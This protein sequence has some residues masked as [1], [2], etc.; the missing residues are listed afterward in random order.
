[1]AGMRI[2]F[3]GAVEGS[4]V[5]LKTLI[6]LGH[7]PVIVVTLPPEAMQRHADYVDLR[8]LAEWAGS[9]VHLTTDINAPG[10]IERLLQNGVDLLV[11]VGWSQICRRAFREAA[12]F[13]AI[14]YHPAPLPRM[15]GRAVIPW[16]IIANETVTGSTVFWL[17]DGADTGGIIA[18][19][20]YGV[21]PDETAR[22]LYEKHKA[23]MPLLIGEAIAK[24]EAGDRRGEAQVEAQASYC[25]KRTAEDGLI[26]WHNDAEDILRLIRA[27]GDPY[28]GAFTFLDG[29]PLTI[30][31]ASFF[32][33]KGRYIGLLGQV[34]T[35]MEEGY[36][37]LCGD[38]AVIAIT[39]WRGGGG[40]RPRVHARLR[41]A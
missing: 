17:D 32:A 24:V 7:A 36:T 9:A 20:R 2:G 40:Q 8:A 37:V 30:D 31:K 14:G 28:P 16:T 10:T 21:A 34:Q 27:V 1:M 22:S 4:L 19:R 26:D 15:R 35:H 25:A 12:R 39:S 29:S 18:Q 23:A 38:G 3:V 6:H 41:P 5:A 11:V 13:G 33:P